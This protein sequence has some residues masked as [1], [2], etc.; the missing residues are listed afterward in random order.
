MNVMVADA[1]TS[2]SVLLNMWNKR[3]CLAWVR[4]GCEGGVGCNYVC[5]VGV[6]VGVGV[7]N[8]FNIEKLMSV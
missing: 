5:V 7:G 1:R 8:C 2:A 3:A 6:G 4:R